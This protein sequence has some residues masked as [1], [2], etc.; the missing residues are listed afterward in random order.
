MTQTIQD[1]YDIDP[2]DIFDDTPA[3]ELPTAHIAYQLDGHEIV[4]HGAPGM[5]A[6]ALASSKGATDLREVE[7]DYK[8]PADVLAAQIAALDEQLAELDAQYLTK[9]VL[10][11]IGVGD[12]YAL[13]QWQA[14]EAAAAP[15]RAEIAAL[16]G[17]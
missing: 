8:T 15:L 4:T 11:G 14:H 16:K 2:I 3:P 10:A 6:E 17:S 5:S 7:A 13:A 1:T 9:R 12:A